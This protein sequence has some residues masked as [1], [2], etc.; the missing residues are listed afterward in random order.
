MF[1]VFS[2]FALKPRCYYFLFKRKKQK[3]LVTRFYILN[4]DI[5]FISVPGPQGTDGVF[6][7]ANTMFMIMMIWIVLALAL[8]FL[9]P[10][11]MRQS[12]PAEKPG[13]SS[14]PVGYHLYLYGKQSRIV[15][16]TGILLFDFATGK[17]ENI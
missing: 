3:F 5:R 11:R 9:R 12:G 13:P 2:N 6:A 10:N 16:Y 4:R 7:G 1:Y 17:K 15:K 8:F 14:R